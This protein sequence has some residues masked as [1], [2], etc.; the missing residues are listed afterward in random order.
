[1]N[2]ALHKVMDSHLSFWSRIALTMDISHAVYKT[3]K[4]CSWFAGTAFL[5]VSG[6]DRGGQGRLNW[7]AMVIA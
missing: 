7:D 5:Q 4:G 3:I 1:M 6:L 2:S